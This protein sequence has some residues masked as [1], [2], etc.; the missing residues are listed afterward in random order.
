MAP[1]SSRSV[2]PANEVKIWSAASVNG[3]LRVFTPM[4]LLV[5]MPAIK[6]TALP[7]SV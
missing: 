4:V 1:E 2:P 3:M 6:V 5:L 7:A